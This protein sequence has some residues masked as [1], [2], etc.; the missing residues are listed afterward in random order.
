M[1]VVPPPAAPASHRFD[2]FG[3]LLGLVPLLAGLGIVYNAAGAV[4]GAS[5]DGAAA[6]HWPSVSGHVTRV[7]IETGSTA[8]NRGGSREIYTPR[9]A[10]DYQV[11]GTRYES[12]QLSLTQRHQEITRS[13]AEAALAP[14]PLGGTV[15]V[16]YDP[17]DPARATLVVEGPGSILYLELGFG[18]L[19]GVFGLYCLWRFLQARRAGRSG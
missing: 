11:E 17:T 1:A 15:E 8:T 16:R 18:L 6:T 3:L 10:Y 2:W 14:Y 5:A 7:W 13:D 9:V 4:I 12:N 19:L